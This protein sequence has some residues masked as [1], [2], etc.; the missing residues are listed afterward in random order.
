MVGNKI[1]KVNERVVFIDEA[2]DFA[3]I[4]KI[5]YIETS[6][7]LG[8]NVQE[9]FLNVANI[10]LHSKHI[11]K[12]SEKNVEKLDGKRISQS[13]LSINNNQKNK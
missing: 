12:K 3:T 1:D 5:P 10:I 11:L 4:N 7:K 9:S 13:N 8:D 6:V 2:L